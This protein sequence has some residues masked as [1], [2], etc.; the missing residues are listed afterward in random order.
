MTILRERK[1]GS[2][3]ARGGETKQKEIVCDKSKKSRVFSELQDYNFII[4]KSNQVKLIHE[5]SYL[6]FFIPPDPA[7]AGEG[8][9]YC[10]GFFAVIAEKS[11]QERERKEERTEDA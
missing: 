11:R 10:R 4:G 9:D 6:H 1:R 3:P 8:N 7:A 2:R 5:E